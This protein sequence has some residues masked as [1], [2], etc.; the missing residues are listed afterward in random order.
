M[1]IRCAKIGEL[2]T[3]QPGK[4]NHHHRH[5]FHLTRPNQQSFQATYEY[6]TAVS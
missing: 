3:Y 6:L 4:A 5:Q 2:M 1:A